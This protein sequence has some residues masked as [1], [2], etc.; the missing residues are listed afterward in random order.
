MPSKTFDPVHIV[1]TNHRIELQY[2]LLGLTKNLQDAAD[3]T[4]E[5]F[6]RYIQREVQPESP[7]AWLFQTGYHLFIDSW[8]KRKNWWKVPLDTVEEYLME[9]GSS[10]E[11][12]VLHKE[13][14]LGLDKAMMK[15]KPQARTALLMAK[16]EGYTYKQIALRL[17][18]S[19][20]TVKSI[21][22]RARMKMRK[23]FESDRHPSILLPAGESSALNSL[24]HRAT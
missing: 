4:Q 23:W 10:P 6:L 14:Q 12:I 11:T 18:C 1:Y 24:D 15:L 3:L 20:N 16:D 13:F 5:T 2:F 21:I 9:E 19:E 22:R 17:G 8:R 7:R